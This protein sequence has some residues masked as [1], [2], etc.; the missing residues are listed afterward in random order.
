[1]NILPSGMTQKIL[2]LDQIMVGIMHK[3]FLNL[4]KHLL[5]MVK[6]VLSRKWSNFYEETNTL[7]IDIQSLSLSWCK[8]YCYGSNELPGSLWVSDNYLGFS[9]VTKHLFSILSTHND[10]GMKSIMNCVWSYNSLVSVVMQSTECNTYQCDKA[11]S[12]AKIFLS[13]FNDKLRVT[14]HAL[15]RELF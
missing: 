9:L 7:L 14:F 3:L 15:S 1:M 4:G 8:C 12:L 5:L 6:S 13:H 11:E 10:E 2:R